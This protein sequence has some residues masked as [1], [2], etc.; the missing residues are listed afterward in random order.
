MNIFLIIILVALIGEYVLGLVANIL[1][2]KALRP[3]APPG[4][5]GVYDPE[6]YRESQEY[7]R[8]TTGFEII[9][10]T[11]RLAVL[12]TF[13]F[14][15]GFNELDEIV[16]GWEL[17][18]IVTGLAYLGILMVA[19]TLVTLPF[20][21]Y[22]TFVIEARFGFNKTTFGTFIADRLKGLALLLALGVPLLAGVLAFF[23]Y[24]GSLA[25][26]Y[27]WAAVTIF[28]L[29]VQF[30][31]PRW[32]MPLFN[33]FTPLEPGE[34]RDSI[35]AYARSVDFALSNVFVIDA[36]KRSTKGNAF[37]T[38]F[39]KNKR[40]ALFDTLV[41]NQTTEEMV[42]VLAHEI[43][44]YKKKHVIQNL[45][46]S[47]VHSGVLLFLLSVF[48]KSDGLFDAFFMDEQSVYAGLLFFGLLYTPVEL[49]L[50]VILQSI[51][52]KHEYE[53]DRWAVETY[54]K[55]QAMAGALKKLSADN[56]SNLGPHPFYV[57]LH[58][59]HPPLRERLHAIARTG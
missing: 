19:Y 14:A 56:L 37:F 26:L 44:H 3:Q 38:G 40:I 33:K 20:D 15:G 34:L 21:V 22:S 17:P 31:A 9:T 49:V 13:W 55:P 30:I 8:V 18:V 7:T 43:G 28:V 50:S 41:K 36:S 10:G 6:K 52:R 2:L 54:G 1:N 35:F 57:F 59:T 53:A 4:L 32:I 58:Y 47:I 27:T 46:I 29:A 25:W 51:S 45:V 23:E 42:A 5:E 12:L 39:G 16:R 48:L 24:A 11:F